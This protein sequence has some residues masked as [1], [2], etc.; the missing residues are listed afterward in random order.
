MQDAVPPP[1]L[2]RLQLTPESGFRA[3]ATVAVYLARL[4][5]THLY[6]SPV[7]EAGRGS[8]HGYDVTDPTRLRSE[9]GGEEEFVRLVERCRDLGLGIVVDF[10]PNHLAATCENAWWKDVL[11]H[12]R[13]SA[14]A[15]FFDIDWDAD[16]NGKLVL[17]VL[18]EPLEDLLN[19]GRVRADPE[20]ASI[21]FDS[22]ALPMAPGSGSGEADVATVVDRQWYRPVFWREGIRLVNYRRFFDINDLAGLRVEDPAVFDAVHVRLIELVKGGYVD[23]IRLDHVDGLREPGAYLRRLRREVGDIPIWVEKILGRGEQLPGD[24]PVEGSTGYEFAAALNGVFVQPG[25]LAEMERLYGRRPFK[26][27]LFAKKL[28]AMDT[29]FEAELRRLAGGLSR[30]S[31]RGRPAA[32]DEQELREAI[33][34]VTAALPVYRTYVAHGGR[35]RADE[36]VL[37][38]AFDG[39]AA[40]GLESDSAAAR[41]LRAV[42]LGEMGQRRA[43]REVTEWVMSWQQLTGPVMAKGAEDSALYSYVTVASMNEVGGD[44]AGGFVGL[45]AI[46]EV[47]GRNA[48]RAPLSI[49]TTS[50][51]DTKRSED[52]RARLNVI[53]ERPDEWARFFDDLRRAV[54]RRAGR[55]ASLGTEMELLVSECL[56]GA[57]PPA[58]LET[59][60]FRDRL[61][62]YGVKAAREAKERTSWLDPDREY[63]ERV[64]TW[65]GAAVGAVMADEG[66]RFAAYVASVAHAGRV[67][68][69][70]QVVVKLTS[71]GIPDIYQGTETWDY[72]LVD[73]DN[74]RP[75][76]FDALVR[77]LDG[78]ERPDVRREGRDREL[79]LFVTSRLLRA[80]RE[81]PDLFRSG[82]YELLQTVG[83]RAGNLYSFARTAGR[84]QV[85]TVVPRLVASEAN[86]EEGALWGGTGIQTGTPAVVSWTNVLTGQTMTA[87]DDH[88]TLLAADLFSELP[89]AVVAGCRPS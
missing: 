11:R 30:I 50:T 6:V 31:I 44:P 32:V 59:G 79:K 87:G 64:E 57:W 36:A 75:V 86:P 28:Q 85:V 62:A 15:G 71:P 7:F 33:R 55:G 12:G 78:L 89:V 24:W 18:G 3:A 46:G 35:S 16:A 76:D 73:P 21:R 37:R 69:L 56:V 19:D 65:A 66:G 74:R 27:H 83:E 43:G 1:T 34:M 52:V 61:A 88:G 2:Y 58:G 82:S 40:R 48:A 72:S 14:F 81:R 80:R 10:V 23:G 13:R 68:S 5:V 51:H 49:N 8:T 17:P 47:C 67:N 4:G 53:S 38:S 42:L 9:L 41:L 45:D 26:D 60:G 77:M 70:A 63:E 39:A 25:G 84:E 54:E 29:L 20:G 22:L